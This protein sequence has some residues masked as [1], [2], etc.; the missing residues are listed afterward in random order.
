MGHTHMHK[1]CLSFCFFFDIS[2][3][4]HIYTY[5]HTIVIFYIKYILYIHIY[6]YV[7]MR[8]RVYIP[9]FEMIIPFDYRVKPAIY[10]WVRSLRKALGSILSCKKRNWGT[11]Y[12]KYKQA[13]T[14]TANWGARFGFKWGYAFFR[15]NFRQQKPKK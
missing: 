2:R 5:T 1:I 15:F 8:A 7:C 13:A 10:L 12:W 6:I 11:E 9:I 3:C 4:K 14:C